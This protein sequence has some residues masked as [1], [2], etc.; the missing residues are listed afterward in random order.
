MMEERGGWIV[1]EGTRQDIKMEDAM[2]EGLVEA[3]HQILE[4]DLN[5]FKGHSGE[6]LPS[7]MERSFSGFL[8]KKDTI[9]FK[10]NT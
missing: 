3:S 10:V 5:P 1:G 7:N 6:I 9:Q 8:V 4:G 2:I